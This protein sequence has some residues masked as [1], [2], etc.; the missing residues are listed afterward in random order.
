MNAHLCER[1]GRS[2]VARRGA[3][4]RRD[5]LARRRAT[6]R[7]GRPRR[8]RRPCASPTCRSR[9]RTATTRR[10]S[11]R[12]RPRR[13]RA[14]AKITVFDANNDP[15]AQFSQ[16]QTAATSKQYDAIIVQPIFGTGLISVVK[17]AIKNGIKVVNMDQELGPN[18]STSKPQ[19]PGLSGNVV[20]VPT[21]DRHEARQARRD[22]VRGEEPQPVQRRLPVRHQG[23]GARRRDPQRLQQGD[24][25]PR[26]RSRSSPRARASSRRRRASR[27]CRRC[28]RRNSDINLIAGSDQGIEGAVQAVDPTQGDAR[29]LRRQRGRPQGRRR[30]QAGTARSC[31]CR[32][33]RGGSPSQC[34]IKAV[35]HRQGLR[36]RRPGRRAPGRGR[37]DEG[38]RLEVQG[39]VARLGAWPTLDPEATEARRAP[40]RLQALRRRPGARRRLAGG[41]ARI[42]ARADRRERRRQVDARQDRRRAST[43]RTTAGCSS[44]ARRCRSARRRRRS[45]TASR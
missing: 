12:P 39:R 11:P 34:A 36:R 26:R 13:R 14:N 8:P 45:S 15:K 44:T 30:R 24:R 23:L 9:S 38:Q 37:R 32:R 4:R 43:P 17:Q 40:G 41:R 22:G 35:A 3:R 21:N 5:G 28:C 6:R 16:L 19:V 20:F 42:G 27:P 2:L 10:C 18:L 25:R 29:R 1:D 31:S 33:A 7:A